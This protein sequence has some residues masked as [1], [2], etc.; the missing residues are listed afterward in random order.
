MAA[1]PYVAEIV[2][3]V[4][5]PRWLY[6][7]RSGAV[8]L[9]LPAGLIYGELYRRTGSIWIVILAHAITNAALGVYVLMTGSWGFW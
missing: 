1:E 6:A 4:L 2:Q 9:V 8:A 3:P 7:V 5:D